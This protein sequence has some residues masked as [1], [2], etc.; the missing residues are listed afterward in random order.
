MNLPSA[1]FDGPVPFGQRYGLLRPLAT[2]GMAEIYLARQ[3][4]M[5]GFEKDIVIKRLKPELA[6][7]PRIVEMFLDEARIGAQLNHPN[8]VHVYDV[9]E[10]GG[11]PYIAMEY[12]VGEELNELCRRGLAHE[13]FLPLPHAVELIRQAAA[14]MGYFH[15][16]RGPGPA[17]HPHAGPPLAIVHCDISPTNLLVTEDGFLKI[18][19]FGIARAADQRAREEGTIP[20]KLSYMSPEQ[21]G[22][23]VVD[24]RSDIFSLGVVL[25]EITVGKRLFKG[26]AQE[27]V[28]RLVAAEIEPPTFAKRDFPGA[29]EGII[30]RALERHPENR[31]QSA[32]DLADDLEGFLRD[33]RLTSGPVRIARYLDELAE[34]AGGFRRPELIS[35]REQARADEELDFDDQMFDGYRAADEEPPSDWDEFQQPDAEVAAA[36]GL[37]LEQLRLMRTPVPHRDGDVIRLPLQAPVE[38]SPTASASEESVPIIVAPPLAPEV[39]PATS[40]APSSPSTTAPP[41]TALAP[42]PPA[43]AARAQFLPWLILGTCAGIAIGILVSL[44]L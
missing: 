32:Y 13:R 28:R 30:M 12:I 43:A 27:V 37:E 33:A 41:P 9:D 44:L 16:K 40:L 26:P 31:Y 20:G 42:A 7:D 25:Y 3:N 34:A 18:I 38:A 17:D 10:E 23:G 14:G 5:A 2:G 29:L 35:E 6:A 39:A 15:A 4:A 1:A 21:A 24:H 8:I 19:D 11:V 22:R 36:L